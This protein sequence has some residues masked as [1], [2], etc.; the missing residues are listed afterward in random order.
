MRAEA[1]MEAHYAAE[2]MATITEVA[3]SPNGDA[4]SGVERSE[5]LA[6]FASDDVGAALNLPVAPRTQNWGL[7]SKSG[8]VY[9]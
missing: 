2:R 4:N 6:E 3:Y 5:G 8:N 9:P 1:R 7:L